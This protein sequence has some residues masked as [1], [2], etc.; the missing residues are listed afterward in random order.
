MIQLL[1]ARLMVVPTTTW[2]RVSRS[3]CLPRRVSS[4]VRVPRASN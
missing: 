2:E 1:Q 4:A 3:A